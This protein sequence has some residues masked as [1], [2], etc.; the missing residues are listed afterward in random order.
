MDILV[1]AIDDA[2]ID[3]GVV[4][5]TLVDPVNDDVS[6]FILIDYKIII[7]NLEVYRNFEGMNGI[8]LGN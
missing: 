1:K 3:F 4:S 6:Y 2:G 5:L 8:T 7:T